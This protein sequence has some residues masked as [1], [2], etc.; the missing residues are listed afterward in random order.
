MYL[1]FQEH[2]PVHADHGGQGHLGIGATIFERFGVLP[3][4]ASHAKS[5]FSTPWGESS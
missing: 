3:S 1:S 2:L 4:L 5:S